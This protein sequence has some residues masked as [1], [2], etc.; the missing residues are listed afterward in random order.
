MRNKYLK[1]MVFF[2]VLMFFGSLSFAADT[3]NVDVTAAIPQQNGLTVTVSKVV[4]KVWST[5][6]GVDFGSLVFDDTNKIFTT[7]GS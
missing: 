3:K 2:T 4:G 5:T 1:T 6:T 7:G